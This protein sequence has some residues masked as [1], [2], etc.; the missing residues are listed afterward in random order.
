MQID[1][2]ILQSYQTDHVVEREIKIVELDVW[3]TI[4]RLLNLLQ[5]A[6]D[7]YCID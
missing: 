5:S 6:A 4:L 1:F 7:N 3:K 2:Q